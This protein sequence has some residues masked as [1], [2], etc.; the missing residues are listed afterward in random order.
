MKVHVITKE[1]FLPKYSKPSIYGVFS[2][3]KKAENAIDKLTDNID[4]FERRMTVV[5]GVGKCY[6]VVKDGE[7]YIRYQIETVEVE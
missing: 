6:D 5:H 1:M 4:G 7:L 2:S 3:K